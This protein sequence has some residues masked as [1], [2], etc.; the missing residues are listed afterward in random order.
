MSRRSASPPLPNQ[1]SSRSSPV[2]AADTHRSSR[3]PKKPRRSIVF[4]S[5]LRRNMSLL[6]ILTLRES[7]WAVL[8]NGDDTNRVDLPRIILKLSVVYQATSLFVVVLSVITLIL[9]SVALMHNHIVLSL[10]ELLCVIFFTIEYVAKVGV[11][12]NR[13]R[14][15][16][17]PMSL[18]DL[19]TVVPVYVSMLS[20]GA[21]SASALVALRIVRLTRVFR[22]FKLSSFN[23]DVGLVFTTLAA[24]KNALVLLVFLF[25]ISLTIFSS[26]IFFSETQNA[27][28][29]EDAREWV[30]KDGSVS[31]FQSIAGTMWWCI[32]TITTVGYGDS[33][34]ETRASQTIAALTMCVGVF[35]IAFP[36]MIFGNTFEDVCE[37]YEKQKAAAKKLKAMTIVRRFVTLLKHR[38]RERRNRRGPMDFS[39]E[40]P[41]TSFEYGG[42]VVEVMMTTDRPKTFWY[43]ASAAFLRNADDSLALLEA[44]VESSAT[45]VLTIFVEL[46]PEAKRAEAVRHLQREF[47]K[48]NNVLTPVVCVH[49]V[50]RVRVVSCNIDTL[51]K[52]VRIVNPDV[53]E[54]G[55]RVGLVFQAEDVVAHDALK[56]NLHSLVL[57]LALSFGHVD[58]H[59]RTVP[60][61]WRCW[62]G[63]TLH[64]TLIT[65]SARSQSSTVYLS[66]A[67][68]SELLRPALNELRPLVDMIEAGGEC[69]FHS[70]DMIVAALRDL[71][72]ANFP[73][74]PGEG[75]G[76]PTLAVDPNVFTR[77]GLFG[78]IPITIETMTGSSPSYALLEAARAAP[79][80]LRS[81]ARPTVDFST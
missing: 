78:T 33:V 51:V 67:V 60:L 44:V 55:R 18:L 71:F 43:H 19:L 39:L 53:P 70:T 35:V 20:S 27:S 77:P 6:P 59:T 21:S 2:A 36:V 31:S 74:A 28:F 68:L 50:S 3:S 61:S 72:V 17:Q 47:P 1:V 46:D 8:S 38:W 10:L 15:V 7:V 22:V 13:W 42:E 49:P 5:D 75:L 40:R 32:A 80:P 69:S 52:G 34:P 30:N 58:V 63:T 48:A 37:R 24:A 9:D 26:L 62:K 81:S 14:F 65:A 57:R 11:A 66:V 29:D 4:E 12:K 25:V 41:I 54:P 23:K 16:R 56:S 45:Y 76:S 73:R 79:Q 64:T